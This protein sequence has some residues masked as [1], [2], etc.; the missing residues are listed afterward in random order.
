MNP[1]TS[2]TL[3]VVVRLVFIQIV[4]LV[5]D[6]M[7]TQGAFGKLSINVMMALL[8]PFWLCVCVA[9]WVSVTAEAQAQGGFAVQVATV[10]TAAEAETLTNSLR[11]RGLRSYW[12]KSDVA[13]GKQI[14]A[15]RI[16]GQFASTQLANEFGRKLVQAKLIRDYTIPR[17]EAPGGTIGE[18]GHALSERAISREHKDAIANPAA[19]RN[20]NKPASGQGTIN[21]TLPTDPVVSGRLREPES[22]G[23][24]LIL[25]PPNVQAV[26]PKQKHQDE[27]ELD[28]F[29]E[30]APNIMQGTIEAR[31]GQLFV[32][33]Q[34][35]NSRHRFRGMVKWVLN[36]GEVERPQPPMQIEIGPGQ[37]QEF[38]LPGSGKSY[39]VTVQD[40]LGAPL[41]TQNGA[42]GQ[43][44]RQGVIA[45]NRQPHNIA[46][47]PVG[48][49][50]DVPLEVQG[51]EVDDGRPRP[52]RPG[53]KVFLE[54][55][56]YPKER[57]EG[58]SG[59]DT[60]PKSESRKE[61]TQPGDVKVI[62]RQVAETAENVTIEF[63]I[64]AREPLG[65]I[66]MTI[67]TASTSDTKQAIM[68]TKQ[69][70][71]PFLAPVGDTN[72]TIGYELRNEQGVILATGSKPFRELGKY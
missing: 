8:R 30:F 33:L 52:P 25:P 51:E 36:D 2:C 16:G 31:E 46:P 59:T 65:M 61:P 12:I 58:E 17:Y 40:E 18:S 32:T 21:S 72:G 11:E 35:R 26:A 62:V 41:L 53:E 42:F 23:A 20:T 27:I 7:L 9:L 4:S 1:A 57:A 34:N 13:G 69:G 71:L 49:P 60:Q 68:T 38:P 22:A 67:H 43:G 47:N 45:E 70:R 64:L 19:V 66:A 5:I 37:T 63:E 39:L 54:T 10:Q 24:Q 3:R 50:G 55:A 48:Q 28:D 29:K 56:N 44:G 14:Y 6:P 15:V